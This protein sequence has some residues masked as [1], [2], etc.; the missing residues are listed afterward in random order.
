MEFVRCCAKFSR[1]CAKF[2]ESSTKIS[3]YGRTMFRCC[4]IFSIY[5]AKF[6]KC[7]TKFSIYGTTFFSSAFVSIF[8]V[9]NLFQR[10]VAP[11]DAPDLPEMTFRTLA[12]LRVKSSKRSQFEH[13]MVHS[14]QTLTYRY[15]HE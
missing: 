7:C 13:L 6:L 2:L 5:G 14:I 4:T 12:Y 11:A 9:V 10:P 15:A 1:C 3:I 8:L